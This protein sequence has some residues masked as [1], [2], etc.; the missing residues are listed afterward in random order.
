MKDLLLNK[1][2]DL[3]V[4]DG[5]FN[6]IEG[7]D[8]IRQKFLIL[9]KTFKGE[10]LLDVNVG[11][12][13]FQEIFTKTMTP[14]R[15]EEIYS[16]LTSSIEGVIRVESVSV[17]EYDRQARY[18]SVTV[19]ALLEG[20][21][22][23]T[24][25]FNGNLPLDACPLDPDKE[26]PATIEGL[27]IWVDA[28]DLS[29]LSVIGSS[30][31][32]ANKAG[33]GQATGQAAVI[34]VSEIG[35]HRAILLDTAES[36]VLTDT[37]AIRTPDGFTAFIVFKNK[38]TAAGQGNLLKLQ[39]NDNTGNP[40]G[41]IIKLNTGA[42]GSLE[43]SSGDLSVTAGSSSFNNSDSSIAVIAAKTA[44]RFIV[45]EQDLAVTGNFSLSLLDGSGDI[46]YNYKG[47]IGE[48]LV[49]NRELTDTEIVNLS[50]YLKVKWGLDFSIQPGSGY[51][52]FA[53]GLSA[54]G[55]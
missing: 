9:V 35:N 43:L 29:S 22:R 36:L 7:V 15:L 5:D 55:L 21:E 42:A 4:T 33:T 3:K 38:E 39:G 2:G 28:Q 26:Y 44:P 12:P 40:E 24:F 19:E 20:N 11:L 34:G 13:Y 49:Y 51:G 30:V 48:V 10:W 45:N 6:I 27:S 14:R 53:Y 31:T 8:Q 54:Y 18:L 1:C 25:T 17:T 46:G 47:L 37:P 41:Y 16:E 52:F 23:S 32:L 50:G